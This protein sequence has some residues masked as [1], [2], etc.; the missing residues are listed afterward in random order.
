MRSIEVTAKTREEAIQEA[1]EKLGA[2]RHEVDVEILDE[3]SKGL[4]GIGA[5]EVKV[6]VVAEGLPDEKG[7][8]AAPLLEEIIRLMGIE[9]TVDCTLTDEG[10]AYL[11]VESS[12]SA[13]LIG[14]KGRNLN[15]M[16]YLVNRMCQT[17][18]EGAAR[19]VIVDVEG[20]VDR[21][22]NALEEMA[23]RLARRAKESGRNM[24]VKPLNPQERR[25]IHMAL[26][27]DPDV[28]TFSL[29]NS[30]FRSV[31]IEPKDAAADAETRARRAP[32][33]PR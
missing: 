16:Q 6:R 1:L 24:R 25:I 26:Q 13:I 23:R 3:G 18:D 12:D 15:A 21:R 4:F 30:L 33:R 32:R 5:R 11:K 28:R 19:R 27:D 9:A 2:E 7:P 20:Y 10:A 29:G 17:G 8:E 22:R 31:I 14:R